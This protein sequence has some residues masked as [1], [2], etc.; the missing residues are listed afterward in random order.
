MRKRS[1]LLAE[2]AGAIA[3][4]ALATPH[5]RLMFYCRRLTENSLTAV[6]NDRGSESVSSHGIH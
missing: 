3:A 2:P 5:A 1:V 4:L 6:T